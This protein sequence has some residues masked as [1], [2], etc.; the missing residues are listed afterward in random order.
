MTVAELIEHLKTLPQGHL[1][2][3][4][5]WSD[6][7]VLMSS[8]ITVTRG[9]KHHNLQ[10]KVRNYNK[11]EWKPGTLVWFCEKCYWWASYQRQCPHCGDLLK[12]QEAKPCFVDVVEF[13]G[14]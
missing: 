5:A 10:D 1:V 4:R 11:W 6:M 7:N 8:D 12:S 9:V 13:P 14:N 3:Y 2:T